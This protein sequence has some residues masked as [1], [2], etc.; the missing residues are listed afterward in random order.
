MSYKRYLYYPPSHCI[1]AMHLI[2]A[3][4]LINTFA[5]L[6]SVLAGGLSIKKAESYYY[7]FI[8][9]RQ[10]DRRTDRQTDK[11]FD[12]MC[13]FFLQVKFVTSLLASLA[14]GL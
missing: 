1:Q 14:G 5:A 6:H 9:D 12:T 4:P 3:M 7:V 10:T 2:Q 11:F 8:S 13:G